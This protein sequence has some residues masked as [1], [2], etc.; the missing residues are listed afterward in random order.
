M[1]DSVITARTSA[2]T[3]LAPATKSAMAPTD[4]ATSPTSAVAAA[5]AKP[6][7]L[8][9]TERAYVRGMVALRDRKYPEAYRQLSGYLKLTE[10]KNRQTALTCEVLSLYLAISREIAIIES[11]L[12]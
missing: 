3:G 9:V 5:T 11:K 7:R 1:K 4:R 8:T 10:N 6:A 2:R 12:G